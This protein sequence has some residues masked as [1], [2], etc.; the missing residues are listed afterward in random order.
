MISPRYCRRCGYDLRASD[1]RCPECG[2]PFDAAD[3]RTYARRP[4]GKPLF[5]WLRRAGYSLGTLLLICV[6]LW[7]WLYLGWRNEQRAIAA[8]GRSRLS[9]SYEPLGGPDL[10]R[11]LGR[12]GLVLDRVSWLEVAGIYTGGVTDTQAAALPAFSYVK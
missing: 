4:L 8:M 2:R 1:A 7:L 10:R 9:V 3:P 12:I 11:W 5:R 6:L